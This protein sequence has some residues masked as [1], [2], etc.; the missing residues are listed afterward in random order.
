MKREEHKS[1]II[2][3]LRES[4][5]LYLQVPNTI[6]GIIDEVNDYLDSEF[7]YSHDSDEMLKHREKRH[8]RECIE[9]LVEK[10]SRK[11]GEKYSSTILE[12]AEQHV[13]DDMGYVPKKE[14]YADKYF[15][16][17]WKAKNEM[18]LNE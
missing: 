11:Y 13:K 14:D 18:F 15:W 8:H 1:R 6:E 12:I 17:K 3:V 7:V 16:E 5:E 9:I 4:N 10:L 2:K